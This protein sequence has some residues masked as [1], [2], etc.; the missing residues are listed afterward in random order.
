MKVFNFIGGKNSNSLTADV[1]FGSSKRV[2]L[3]MAWLNK[4]VHVVI[5]L[6]TFFNLRPVVGGCISASRRRNHETQWKRSL[7]KW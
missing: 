2:R 3:V 6:K 5:F 1:E 7:G 4:K